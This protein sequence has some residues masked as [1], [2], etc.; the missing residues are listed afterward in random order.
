[1]HK[2]KLFSRESGYRLSLVL[3]AILIALII[4]EFGLRILL[5]APAEYYVWPPN[6]RVTFDPMPGAMPGISG[7]SRFIINSVGIRGDEFSENQQYRILTMGGSTTECLYLDEEEAWPHLLQ[8]QLNSLNYYKVWVGNIGK[9]ALGTPDHILH[10][11]YLLPQYPRID[12]IILLIGAAEFK[13]ASAYSDPLE[14]AFAIYPQYEIFPKDTALWRLGRQ[15]RNIIVNVHSVQVTKVIE[16]A[17]KPYILKREQRANAEKI[18]EMPDL[19]QYLDVYG[20]NLNMIIDMARE[21]SIRLICVTQPSIYKENMSEQEK[22]LIWAGTVDESGTK[23]YSVSVLIDRMN[24]INDETVAICQSQGVEYI[25]LSNILPKDTTVFYDDFHFNE[26]G[27]RLV[28][29]AIFMYLSTT[30]PFP[31]SAS[32]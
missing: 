19:S 3:A 27:A 31:H 1:M 16:Q 23:Y 7:E 14:H 17:G 11:K 4:A 10:M 20:R 22:A 24:R 29:Q 8:E 30:E 6:Y 18:D 9:S 5:P 15:V 13:P 2:K 25:D 32:P 12:A 21:R 26:N 28:S